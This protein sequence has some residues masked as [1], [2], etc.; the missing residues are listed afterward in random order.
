MRGNESNGIR[1]GP[2]DADDLAAIRKILKKEAGSVVETQRE[3][4]SLHSPG[5]HAPG[6]LLEAGRKE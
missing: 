5:E 4:R 1:F 2:S 3:L 6:E